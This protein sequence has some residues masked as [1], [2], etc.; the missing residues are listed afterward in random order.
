MS[1]V[2]TWFP[3]LPVRRTPPGVILAPPSGVGVAVGNT[4]LVAVP[5]GACPPSSAGDAQAKNKT[6]TPSKPSTTNTPNFFPNINSLLSQS[7]FSENCAHLSNFFTSPLEDSKFAI[8]KRA[9]S[10]CAAPA[11]VI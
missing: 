5:P 9:D 8:T 7:P 1:Q 6:T 4:T 10:D 3:M 2:G 11:L